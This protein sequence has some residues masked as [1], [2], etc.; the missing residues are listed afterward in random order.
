MK[1]KKKGVA[2]AAVIIVVSAILLVVFSPYLLSFKDNAAARR[3]MDTDLQNVDNIVLLAHCVEIEGQSNSV[4]GFKESLRQGADAVVV[5]LCFKP[6]GTPVMTDDYGKI[7]SAPLLEKLF[8]T[9]NE[10]KYAESRVFLNIIQLSNFS[11][12]NK[13]VVDYNLAARLTIIGID[14]KHYELVRSE[15]TIVPLYLN[16]KITADDLSAIDDGTF[17]APYVIDKYG[18][19]GIVI[20]YSDC[21]EKAI[22]ALDDYGIPAVVGS[23]DTASQFCSVLSDNAKMVYVKNA[24]NSRNILDSWI[25]AMQDR[26]QSSVEKSLEELSKK[27][28]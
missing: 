23:V 11:V 8:K 27:N 19:D 17:E 6:D 10:E 7:N 28:K 25:T 21:S 15:D 3:Y 5:D 20:S 14:E 16:Y 2:A 9:M 18:A 26:Y 4:A 1:T 24:E 12:L 22:E 13:L